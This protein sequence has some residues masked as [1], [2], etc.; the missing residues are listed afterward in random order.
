MAVKGQENL[1]PLNERAKDEQREIARKGGIARGEQRREEKLIKDSLK[2]LLAMPST[3]GNETIQDDL[4]LALVNAGLGGNV[5]AI[6][7][8]RDTLGQKPSDKVE[9]TNNEMSAEQREEMFERIM[10]EVNNDDQR[11]KESS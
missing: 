2:I 4:A 5:K 11:P 1:I 6:E 10:E 9:V 3:K 7:T 8:I